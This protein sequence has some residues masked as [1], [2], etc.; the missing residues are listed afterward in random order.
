MAVAASPDLLRQVG[1]LRK[2]RA[3]DE[4]LGRCNEVLAGDPAGDLAAR[5]HE[6]KAWAR[7]ELG[8]FDD[9]AADLT[10]AADALEDASGDAAEVAWLRARALELRFRAVDDSSE[11]EAIVAE[12]A[13]E[14][15]AGAH[16]PRARAAMLWARARMRSGPRPDDRPTAADLV[17]ADHDLRAAAQDAPGYARIA[18][19]RLRIRRLQTRL[20]N[21]PRAT[22]IKDAQKYLEVCKSELETPID[23]DPEE[24]AIGLDYEAGRFAL[25]QGK[26]EHAVQAL[27][28]VLRRDPG[29]QGANVWRVD[30][31]R[32]LGASHDSLL[33][34]VDRLFADPELRRRG[35]AGVP[36]GTPSPTNGKP[37]VSAG[38]VIAPD[39]EADLLTERAIMLEE[40]AYL[41][42]ARADFEHALARRPRMA[43]AH[44]GLF[45]CLMKQGDIPGAQEEKEH[46]EKLS[47]PLTADLLVELGTLPFNLR[48][49]DEALRYFDRAEEVGPDYGL[50][51]WYEIAARRAQ[52][53]E[54]KID[55]AIEEAETALADHGESLFLANAVRV[56]IGQAQLGLV[57]LHRERADQAVPLF[58]QA[59]SDELAPIRDL[60]H[61][62][63]IDAHRVARRF[64]EAVAEAAAAP[65]GPRVCEAAG[66]LYGEVG[67]LGRALK[68]FEDGLETSPWDLGLIVGKARALRLLGRITEARDH[69]RERLD[70]LPEHLQSE[71]YV[72]LGLTY[73][74]LRR[75][76]DA[77]RCFDAALADTGTPAEPGGVRG[78]FMA[79]CQSNLPASR[80][81]HLLNDGLGRF[82]GRTDLRAPLLL[83]GGRCALRR[84]DPL[85]ARDRF[86]EAKRG[87]TS[88]L[89]RLIEGECLLGH[90]AVSDAEAVAD[91][92]EA[93]EEGRYRNDPAVLALRAR[94]QYAAGDVEAAAETFASVLDRW[95]DHEPATIGQA[96]A[97]FAAGETRAACETLRA[98]HRARP[99]N[100]TATEQLA[101]VLVSAHERE[102]VEEARQD[103]DLDEAASLCEEIRIREPA[104]PGVYRC[105]AAIARHRGRL[106]QAELYLRQAGRLRPD[107]P[108]IAC[109]S[110]TVFL[111]LHRYRD[112]EASLRKAL[113]HDPANARAHFVFGALLLER[114]QPLRA[115]ARFK[116]SAALMPG[117]ATA[118]AALATAF[119]RADKQEEAL[120]AVERGLAETPR[121]THLELH[122]A[123]AR[124]LYALAGEREEDGRDAL[125]G[126]A[127][128]DLERSGSLAKK[129]TQKAQLHY[130]RGVIRHGQGDPKGARREF[131]KALKHDPNLVDARRA[132]QLV[133]VAGSGDRSERLT[134]QA[135]YALGGLGIALIVL[136]LVV[137]FVEGSRNPNPDI[138]DPGWFPVVAALLVAIVLGG[139]LPRLAGLKFRG[140]ELTVSPLPA[141]PEPSPV[142][143]G[144]AEV[145]LLMMAGPA[146]YQPGD[147]M[148]DTLGDQASG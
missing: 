38:A 4:L 85:R 26:L 20:A 143:L 19:A 132:L 10:E 140:M 100:L 117:E 125:L 22:D 90:R 145:P 135:G 112:A 116:R 32:L 58:Q 124:A 94:C 113:E 62:G 133:P 76:D 121:R 120:A 82:D 69:L 110:G 136:A 146:P 78:R 64:D 33:P 54:V 67:E 56:S 71:L 53:D 15:D 45:R 111:A 138:F 107:D 98:L 123:K 3:Y 34:D 89:L 73:L 6:T 119:A 60:A 147:P 96:L 109:D 68:G 91:E 14:I 55:E 129:P 50:A 16:G 59:T 148:T 101:W 99:G 23:I 92:V 37:P 41:T 21:T 74:E 141:V 79:A 77:V 139:V 44:R 72:E 13:R 137:G 36:V 88:L 42:E 63:L 128:R 24:V 131:K 28:S 126:E 35:P 12:V 18:F 31:L 5:M 27:D 97:L 87:S 61:A 142:T 51:Y 81:E 127:E 70:L 46:V 52:L 30:A 43:F 95:K 9:A 122:L 114:G 106:P 144:F 66:W 11:K 103:Q 7:E 57:N 25:A 47:E 86:E 84:G 8:A 80:L 93:M 65:T 17:R 83:E 115:V 104:S 130:H 102:S 2:D 49:Y 39:H 1:D 108:E 75:M 118:H 29:H 48:D 105:L 40:D 134:R